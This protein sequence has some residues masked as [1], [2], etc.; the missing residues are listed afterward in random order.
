VTQ[1]ELDAVTLPTGST[2]DSPATGRVD[3]GLYIFPEPVLYV[4]AWE[5][6]TRVHAE[7]VLDRRAD[8]VLI[9]EHLPVYT[10]GRS[11]RT[12]HLGATEETLRRV[13]DLQR[14]NR[15]GSVTYHGPGQILLYPIVRLGTYA[16]GPKHFVWL[17]EEV[18]IRLLNRW[19][20]EGTRV[21]QKPGVWVMYPE[22][23]K[24]ASI[25][26]RV[27][28]GVSLHGLAL[29]VDMDLSPFQLIHPC[30]FSDCRMTSMAALLGGS[31]SLDTI[32]SDLG[33]TFSALF[34]ARWPRLVVTTCED[35][36]GN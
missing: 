29:N 19:A 35:V 21:P 8:T 27:E 24:I 4:D 1:A 11:T 5:L 34:A 28:H 31:L 23:A 9:L 7:R 17:L 25:G 33:E 26:V 2:H 3:G 16:A 12:S 15:G 18:L 36:C 6:Q 20:I 32:K 14:V 30:G 10:L 22:P 13:A